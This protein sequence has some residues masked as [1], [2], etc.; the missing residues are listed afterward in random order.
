MACS[1]AAMRS[2]EI[3]VGGQ[4]AHR[5]AEVL[6]GHAGLVE[7]HAGREDVQV[8]EAAMRDRI[9]DHVGQLVRMAGIG[10]P[11]PACPIGQQHHQGV[12]RQ[13]AVV[14]GRGF[15]LETEHRGRRDLP[16]GEA[17]DAV[18]EQ[19]VGDVDVAPGGMRDVAA[20]DREAVAV[21]AD[22]DHRQAVVRHLDAGRDRQRPAVQAVKAVGVHEEREAR[23]AAD[24]R[25]DHRVLGRDAE[26]VHGA[27]DAL[28]HAEIAAAGTPGRQR[29][30][31]V[32]EA[33]GRLDLLEFLLEIDRLGQFRR[34]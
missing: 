30:R 16:L 34:G 28:G 13:V 5:H 8:R 7:R 22:H 11:D 17:V 33:P 29:L 6:I 10:L 21:A 12:Q 2:P 24:A 25:D 1:I 32:L 18:V 26:L 9:G 14:V 15:R 31:A 23:R 20:A 27:G 19:Q 4:V 3:V